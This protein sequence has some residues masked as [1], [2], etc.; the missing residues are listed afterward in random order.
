MVCHDSDWLTDSEIVT[1]YS[2]RDKHPNVTAQRPV[3]STTTTTTG[4]TRLEK[5]VRLVFIYLSAI[6]ACWSQSA[7]CLNIFFSFSPL[8]CF[9]LRKPNLVSNVVKNHMVLFHWIGNIFHQKTN[10]WKTSRDP[11]QNII[12]ILVQRGEDS[13]SRL[14]KLQGGTQLKDLNRFQTQ[15]TQHRVTM[16][17]ELRLGEQLIYCELT[18]WWQPGELDWWGRAGV[19]ALP[20]LC[21][22]AGPGNRMPTKHNNP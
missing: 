20:H 22:G 19:D 4:E 7:Q 10:S 15:W 9:D 6:A 18:S 17:Q 1:Q 12:A 3:G 21:R 13:E 5:E 8:T 14:V 16:Q 11:E 2:V